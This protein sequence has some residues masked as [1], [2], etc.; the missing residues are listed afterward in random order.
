MIWLMFS[1]KE[2][3]IK[4][5]LINLFRDPITKILAENSH[6]T[7]AQLETFLIDILAEKMAQKPMIYE[8]KAKLRPIGEGVSRGSF[9]RTLGQ[10]QRNIIRSIY[11]IILLGYLGI[12]DSP[13]L[14]PYFVIANKL[15]TYTEAYRDAWKNKRTTNEHMK[16]IKIL[17]N[18]IERSLQ[19]LTNAKTL[20]KNS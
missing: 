20:S 4:A 9:N 6:L 7:K 2:S 12:Q 1:D 8:D 15:G 13:C 10:A 17:H 3:G 16:I 11:T 14:E 19:E 18:E 5:W